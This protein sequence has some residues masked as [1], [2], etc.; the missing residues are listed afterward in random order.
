MRET[1]EP[2]TLFGNDQGDVWGGLF[3]QFLGDHMAQSGAL[4]IAALVRKQLNAQNTHEQ[5][6]QQPAHP[7]AAKRSAGPALS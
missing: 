1:L 4:G 2:N 7:G 6:P 5:H 3:D